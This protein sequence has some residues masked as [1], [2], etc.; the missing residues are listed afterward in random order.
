MENF[1]DCIRSR[2]PPVCD[3]E[4]GHRSAS[5]CHLGVIALRLG[6]KLQWDPAKEAFVGDAE[7]DTWISREMRKG[8]GY[9]FLR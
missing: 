8:Y 9:E 3:A 1:F 7:A 2:Q 4:I 5:V 6:R